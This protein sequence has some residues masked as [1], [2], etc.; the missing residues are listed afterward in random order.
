MRQL[1]QKLSQYWN[2]IQYTL[3]PFLEEEWDPLT[4]KQQ[5]LVAILEFV[6]IEQFLPYR[7]IALQLHG[8]LSQK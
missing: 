7:N 6:R 3:F 5:Q 2:K 1:G 4:E 8:H